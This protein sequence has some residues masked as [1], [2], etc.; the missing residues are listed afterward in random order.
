MLMHGLLISLVAISGVRADFGPYEQSTAYDDGDYGGWPTESFRSTPVI[1]PSLNILQNSDLCNDG[2]IMLAPEG[3]AVRTPGPMIIDQDGHLVWTKQ[4][5]QTRDVSVYQFKGDPYLTFCVG[6]HFIAGYG[7]ASTCYMLDS[8]YEE[9]YKIRG[10]ND[11]AVDLNDFH[12]TRDDTAL[13]TVRNHVQTDLQSVDRPEDG[14]IVDGVFQEVNIETGELLFQWQAAEHFNFT[15]AY[16]ELED[17]G[18][19]ANPW[20]FFH[21]SGLDK[22][23]KGNFL[24][25]SASMNCLAYIDGQSGDVIWK[26]GGKDN[27]FEDLSDGDTTTIIQPYRARFTEDGNAITLFDTTESASRGL[28]LDVDQEKMTVQVRYQ[29]LNPTDLTTKFGGSVQL[30]DNSNVLVSYGSSAA[31]TEYSLEGN[32]LC[33][34]HFGS[35]FQFNDDRIAS[36]HV[37]KHAWTGHPKTPPTLKLIGYE[38]VVSWNGATEVVTWALEGSSTIPTNKKNLSEQFTLITAQFKEGFETVLSIPP[39]TSEHV[40]R[41]VAFDRD[42]NPLGSSDPVAWN[43]TP[44]EMAAVGAM[45]AAQKWKLFV[46]FLVGFLSAA[47]L[48][49]G[50]WVIRRRLTRG[51]VKLE[52]S[53]EEYERARGVWKPA[54]DPDYNGDE[55]LSDDEIGLLENQ[56]ETNSRT[57]IEK[58]ALKREEEL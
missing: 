43:P 38:A 55:R 12:I 5:G 4:Y 50:V 34:V 11:L 53:E 22:D 8:S 40:F 57:S 37:S 29:Y 32:P 44:E 16:P 56:A 26:V 10:A 6:P 48:A 20:D 30:L 36:Q 21:I 51:V 15:E 28:F 9:V 7:D 39:D 54:A 1:G 18:T 45:T 58:E 19:E 42:G 2:Y 47:A 52:Q 13:L 35:A 25:S 24:V 33:E 17:T 14:W 27:M 31:W 49:V 23:E 41:V 46:F 3:N